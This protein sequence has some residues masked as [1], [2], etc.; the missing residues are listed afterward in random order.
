MFEFEDP[1]PQ[2]DADRPLD[3]RK[4]LIKAVVLLVMLAV[5]VC[6]MAYAGRDIWTNFSK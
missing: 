3:P 5:A 2:L 1:P 4:T 6:G